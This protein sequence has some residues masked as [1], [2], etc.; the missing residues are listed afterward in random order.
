MSLNLKLVL[1]FA[2]MVALSTRC[3]FALNCNEDLTRLSGICVQQ[4]GLN[5][6][7]LEQAMAKCQCNTAT[8]HCSGSTQTQNPAPQPGNTTPVNQPP[9]RPKPSAPASVEPIISETKLFDSLRDACGRYSGAIVLK[10]LP[11]GEVLGNESAQARQSVWPLIKS[12]CGQIRSNCAGNY[13]SIMT[14]LSSQLHC[15][16]VGARGD[17][18]Q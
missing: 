7:C 5:S 17:V 13:H 18:C 2:A 8:G 11:C 12:A 4:Q 10:I 14:D 9:V 6:D 16:S 15:S 1:F 3:A